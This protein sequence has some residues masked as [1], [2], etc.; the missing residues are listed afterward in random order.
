MRSYE[1]KTESFTLNTE[2]RHG[3]LNKNF[4]PSS[5]ITLSHPISAGIYR[6]YSPLQAD[7]KENAEDSKPTSNETHPGSVKSSLQGINKAIIR[8]P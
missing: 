8:H 7:E 3:Y 2:Q 5:R 4:G 6:K 1:E